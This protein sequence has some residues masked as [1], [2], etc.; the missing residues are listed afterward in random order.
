MANGH[1][2]K[3]YPIREVVFYARPTRSYRIS[4]RDVTDNMRYR[5]DNDER[6]EKECN[7]YYEETKYEKPINL[8]INN[9]Y[10]LGWTGR[11]DTNFSV[12]A[13]TELDRLIKEDKY[14]LWKIKYNSEN[15]IWNINSI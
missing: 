11:G 10:I 12:F 1:I 15:N 2:E 4:M 13:P 5:D 6:D 8:N 14:V 7:I 9:E 3:D